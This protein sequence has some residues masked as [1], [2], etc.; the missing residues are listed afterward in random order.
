MFYIYL[1]QNVYLEKMIYARGVKNKIF[2]HYIDW[3]IYRDL[4][5]K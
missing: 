1:R 5:L 3:E 4:S 2:H